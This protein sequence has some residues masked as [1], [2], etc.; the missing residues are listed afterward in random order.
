M[1]DEIL[2]NEIDPREKITEELLDLLK[3][4]LTAET[5]RE[6]LDDYHE[7]DVA[8]V[9]PLLTEEERKQLY[10][11]LDDDYLS[12]VF[13]YLDDP[14]PYIEEMTADKAADIIESMAA[15]DAV[16]VLDELEEDK[17]NEIIGLM[18]EDS[19]NDVKLIT[20]YDDDCIGSRMTTDYVS[21]KNDYNIKTAM[22][23]LVEQAAENDNI[24]TIY[25]TDENNVFYGAVSL[26]K[27]FIARSDTPLDDIVTTS[28]PYL[29]ADDKIVDALPRIKEY[30]E[31]SL[32]VLDADN[33]LI[34]VLTS[35][36]VVEAVDDEISEDYAK[37]AGLSEEDDLSER[38]F[39]SVKKRLP[40]LA[41]LLVLSFIVSSVLKVFDGVMAA[42]PILVFFQTMVLDMSGNA[43]TQSLGVTIRRLTDPDITAADK[44]R[45]FFSELSIS[46]FDALILATLAFGL[47]TAYMLIFKHQP[48]GQAMPVAACIAAA[49]AISMTVSGILGTA[50]PMFFKKTGIDPAAASGPLIT[51]MND[52]LSAVTYYGLAALLLLTIA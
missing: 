28:F 24:S 16:D 35:A 47:T 5:L 9:I 19:A 4:D 17:K 52:L 40:W 36:D 29:Y 51:T 10:L 46:F 45:A 18:D 31:E 6:K 27:L 30:E 32:P 3:S 42:L 2:T 13:S 33:R 14:E 49:M 34:G 20:G 50:I 8:Q 21:I 1:S 26:N 39:G 22:K 12:E 41:A 15:D 7:N 44:R 11:K 37:L 23:S 25:V 48:V 38:V 43:S